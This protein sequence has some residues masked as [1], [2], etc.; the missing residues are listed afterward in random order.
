MQIDCVHAT[1]LFLLL[2]YTC[3]CIG[4]DN[5]GIDDD[6]NNH[7]QT[8]THA[9]CACVIA[10][11]PVEI[12]QMSETCT[13]IQTNSQRHTS[14]TAACWFIFHFHVSLIWFCYVFLFSLSLSLSH[15]YSLFILFILSVPLFLSC[16]IRS[17]SNWVIWF[18]LQ[19]TVFLV[20]MKNHSVFLCRDSVRCGFSIGKQFSCALRLNRYSVTIACKTPTIAVL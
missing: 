17:F 19:L 4:D 13:H 3:S 6:D 7:T 1:R 18:F 9:L 14:Y 11:H 2:I 15:S 16:T 20:G 12:G 5:N 8:H 10:A